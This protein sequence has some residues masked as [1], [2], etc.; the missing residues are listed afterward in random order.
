MERLPMRRVAAFGFLPVLAGIAPILVIPAIA[1]QLGEQGWSAI[2]VG[3][4]VGQVGAILSA[5]A[6]PVVG[7][8]LVAGS[9]PQDQWHEFSR[10]IRVRTLLFL[11][12]ALPLWW[13]ATTLSPGV[14]S[15]A[16][17][18]SAIAFCAYGLGPGWYFVGVG[19]AG[20]VAAFET[21]PRLISTLVAIGLLFLTGSQF[22]Y[23]ACVLAG[24]LLGSIAAVWHLRRRRLPADDPTPAA[25]PESRSL[26]GQ[27]SLTAS[28]LITSGYTVAS[29]AIVS[30]VA[31]G[32]SVVAAF[33]AVFRI[34]AMARIPAQTLGTSLQGWVAEGRS[35]SQR[36]KAALAW[37]IGLG[38]VVGTGVALLLPLALQILFLGTVSTTPFVS[39]LC[40]L[41][42]LAHATSLSTSIHALIPTGRAHLVSVATV[43]ASFVGVPLLLWL[44][45][46]YGVDGAVTALLVAEALVV[47]IELPVTMKIIAAMAATEAREHAAAAT[48]G[49]VPE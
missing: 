13:I 47:A 39:L 46:A 11:I 29:T 7:P 10:S 8:A 44:T 43:I 3:Q 37:M 30:A 21:I 28:G 48:P 33:A 41:L 22:A 32:V 24:S 9:S 6:W 40:G 26:W 27:T 16:A 4:S 42:V 12:S 18:L 36:M 35:P 19:Q 31:P 34:Q 49:S 45:P 2:A 1:A 17:G 23:P 38:L 14:H 25:T 15:A 20:G 5:F